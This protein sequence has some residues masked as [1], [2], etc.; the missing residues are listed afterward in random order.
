MRL[1]IAALLLPIAAALP[2]LVVGTLD[3][4]AN[5]I[6]LGLLFMAASAAAPFLLGFAILRLLWRRLHP[7][8]RR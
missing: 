1:V 8:A 7:S 4:A 6:G 2:L 3:P 5:P